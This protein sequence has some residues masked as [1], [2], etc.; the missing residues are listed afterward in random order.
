MWI[1]MLMRILQ[2]IEDP[3]SYHGKEYKLEHILLFSILG[4]LCNAK[5]YTDIAT[6]IKV[7]YDLLNETF[8]LKWRVRPTASRA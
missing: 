2:S 3:R 7:K 8:K 5:T 4:I 6:F 1:I